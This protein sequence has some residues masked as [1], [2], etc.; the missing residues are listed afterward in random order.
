M[1]LNEYDTET[2]DRFQDLIRRISYEQW[3]LLYRWIH[4]EWV[5]A[6]KRE[7]ERLFAER[8]LRRR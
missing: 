1:P 8:P 4:T 3:R 5:C 7:V 6:N 2:V